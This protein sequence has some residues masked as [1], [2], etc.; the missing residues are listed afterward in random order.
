METTIHGHQR[1]GDGRPF[2]SKAPSP[3]PLHLSIKGAGQAHLSPSST[4][5]R[6]RRTLPPSA[7][8]ELH[9]P[10]RPRPTIPVEPPV[11][12]RTFLLAEPPCSSGSFPAHG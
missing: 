12:S 10:R 6:A 1:R 8:P 3:I 11:I 5:A 4:R 7:I 2:L 9:A